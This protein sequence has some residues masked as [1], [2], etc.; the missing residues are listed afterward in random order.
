M[1]MN[2]ILQALGAAVMGTLMVSASA[3]E[4]LAFSEVFVAGQDGFPAIRIPSIVITRQGT[5]LAFAE[6]RKAPRADQADNE[7][8]LKRSVDAGKTWS[9]PQIIAADG[10][11]CLNNPCAVVDTKIGRVILMFQSYP[12]GFSERDGKIL[13]GLEGE[14]IVRNYVITSDDGVMWSKP[15]DVTRTTKHAER[16]TIVASGPGVGIQLQHGDHAG[17]IIMPF[18]EGPFG[19]WNVLAVFSDDGGNHWQLGEP[20]PGCCITNAA[21][22]VTSLVN[23]VQMVELKGG[24]VRLNSRKWGGPALRKTAVSRDGGVTWSPIVEEPA[25]RDPGCMGSIIG[26]VT[27]GGQ[28]L[29]LYSGPDSTKRENGTVY[30]SRDDGQTWPVKKVIFPGSFAYSV[31]IQLPSGDIGCLFETDNTDRI[32]FARIPLDWLMAEPRG[33]PGTR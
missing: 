18:N 30:L 6:G 31:L 1:N 10:K 29:L 25:L 32:V 11:N 33:I 4:T 22:K 14:A 8:M 15:L 7:I 2:R 5:L 26:A 28:R 12:F 27:K 20:A 16:V 3:A 13:P 23:E 21:G 17:R 9:A 19:R 24:A